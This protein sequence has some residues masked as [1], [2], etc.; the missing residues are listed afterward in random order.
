MF[1]IFKGEQSAHSNSILTGEYQNENAP[2]LTTAEDD[3]LESI[4][5]GDG[6]RIQ[7]VTGVLPRLK[8]GLFERI[9]FRALRG[10]MYLN[11]VEIDEP[12]RDANNLDEIVE[13]NVFIVFAHGS[14]LLGKVRKICES[15][16]ATLYT[17]DS[18]QGKRRDEALEVMNR[19]EDLKHVLDTTKNNRRLELNKVGTKIEEWATIILQEKAIHYTMNLFNY[20]QGRKALI[21]EGWCPTEMIGPIQSSLRTVSERTNSTIPPILSKLP[22]TSE[23]PPTYH[24]TN[25]FTYAFQAIVDAYGIAT[26]REVN[27]GLFTTISFPFLFAVMFGDMGHGFLVFLF[28]AWMCLSERSLGRKKWGEM[29][30]MIFG[31]RYIL[32]LMGVFSVFTGLM[33]NDI[34][35]RPLGLFK[36]GYLFSQSAPEEP[37]IAEKI[38]TY[39][40]GLDPAW[41]LAENKL[42]FLNSYK[43]KMAIVMGFI[44]MMFGIS[45]QIVNHRFFKKISNIYAETLPQIIFMTCIIGY[46][47]SMT[48]ENRQAPS[49]LNTLIFMF[50]SPGNVEKS[51]ELYT[52]Q[53]T[54]QL[55]LLFAAV[56]CVPWM[57]IGKPYLVW[58][59][60]H[61][62]K[63]SLPSVRGGYQRL[64]VVGGEYEDMD[65]DLGEAHEEIAEEHHDFSEVIVH[66]VL[67]TIEFVL[68]SI[69]NTASYLRL[70][71]LSLAH[72]QLSEVLWDMV[73][74]ACFQ[75]ED[76]YI[77]VFAL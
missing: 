31:G 56:V 34:F 53:A 76:K 58:K 74:G 63:D 49:L 67:H 8:M 25:K 44:Q 40:F 19:L 7:Y 50:L 61:A 24:R 60:S 43:M 45:I 70:W 3:L 18:N 38:G 29:W 10:N 17:V 9:L 11:W 12:L 27:P 48:F 6:A 64:E 52:G 51:Q 71:A 77:A 35:S 22:R 57:L 55:F 46:L 42:L 16:G 66:Q 20:D 36:S 1:P 41:M 68:N 28:A 4:E 54:V 37:F 21:A 32:L 59:E 69:S 30:D 26:Y 23:A 33:Y 14:Q 5:H 13:K 75:I 15:L 47:W 39:P 65:D 72:A 2:L 73:M 62:H